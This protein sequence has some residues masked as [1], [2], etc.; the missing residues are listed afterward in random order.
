MSSLHPAEQ[1]YNR[2]KP[3][4]HWF[5]QSAMRFFNSRLGATQLVGTRFR[6][7]VTSEKPPHGPRAYCVRQLDLGTGDIDTLAPGICG[8]ATRSTAVRAMQR[9]AVEL[10]AAKGGG[11]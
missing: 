3:D 6:L 8:I 1:D 9:A 11:A 10:A 2:L 7:F 4:G 5:E